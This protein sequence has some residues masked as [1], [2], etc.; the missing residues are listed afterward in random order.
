[1][2]AIAKLVVLEVWGFLGLLLAIVAVRVLTGSINTRRLLHGR[3]DRGRL[4]FS[5]ERVQL[6]VL[7]LGV[8]TQFVLAV[9][10]AAPAHRMPDVPTELL[11]VVGGSQAFYLGGKVYSIVPWRRTL[12]SL[13]RGGPS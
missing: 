8:A 11:A 1:M 4:Y 10:D 6:L 3:L 7:T 12:R 5:P 2:P 13:M 9:L